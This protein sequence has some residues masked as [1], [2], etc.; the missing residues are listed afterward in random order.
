[1]KLIYSFGS[2]WPLQTPHTLLIQPRH[3]IYAKSPPPIPHHPDPTRSSVGVN[4]RPNGVGWSG[5]AEAGGP[6]CSTLVLSNLHRLLLNTKH[7]SG[8]AQSRARGRG[9]EGEGG[10]G[11]LWLP[12]TPSGTHSAP[13]ST[14]R[15]VR[16]LMKPFDWMAAT[17][18]NFN[19][20]G[21][22]ISSHSESKPCSQEPEERPK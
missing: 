7:R 1:M 14:Q 5:R 2:V 21:H 10:G 16:I 15:C 6:V 4:L 12:L 22:L 20:A 9:R 19:A 11:P 3:L 13:V 18:F 17:K 8:D